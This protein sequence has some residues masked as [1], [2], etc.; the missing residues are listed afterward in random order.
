MY[1]SMIRR[2]VVGVHDPMPIKEN[3]FTINKKSLVSKV[4][5]SKNLKESV[6]K[7]IDLIG[8]IKKVIYKG[9][10]VLIKPNYVFPV[11]YPCCT[12]YDFLEAVIELVKEA[13]AFSVTVGECS[14][15]T[16]RAK[17]IME[18]LAAKKICDRQG[19]EIV[20][21]ADLE[22]LDV[23]VGDKNIAFP[24]RVFD[25]DKIIYV[26][27]MKTHHLARFSMSLKHTMGFVHPR[28]RFLK[29]HGKDL[30][31]NIAEINKVICPDLVLIDG[32]KCFVTSG[33]KE[34]EVKE[35]NL[36]LASGDRVAVDVE[37]LKI[38]MSYKAENLLTLKK[39]FDYI[40][41]R[42]ASDF[43]LGVKKETDIMVVD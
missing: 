8:G 30:E 2:N 18:K 34:G 26:G 28:D 27:V 25:Y 35:P 31:R 42:K 21:F 7:S 39:P 20:D 40:Q 29:M 6:K 41:I 1:I 32:R 23:K 3:Q 4:K 38:L 17:D 11:D 19:V 16:H 43:G 33:P 10:S 24:K 15:F 9:D 14:F 13:G 22:W 5:V 12:S 36:I 37:A